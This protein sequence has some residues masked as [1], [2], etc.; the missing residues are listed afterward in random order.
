MRDLLNRVAAK[1]PAPGGGSASAVAC[2]LAAG[3]VEMAAGFG[4]AD[5]RSAGGRARELRDRALE[6][7]TSDQR[8][9]EPVLVALRLPA[10]D[11]DRERRLATAASD[12]ARTPLEI[13]EIGAE[14]AALAV[15]CGR[16]GSRYLDGDATTAALLA[17]AACRAAVRLVEINLARAADDGQLAR[18]RE[19]A[20][21]AASAREQTLAGRPEADQ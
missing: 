19:F 13:A 4:G 9:Y 5:L 16:D 21:Q 18:A 15:R 8:S 11:P 2:A 14:L 7:A 6:L 17:E 1:T 10:D 12:A 3:L 20:A